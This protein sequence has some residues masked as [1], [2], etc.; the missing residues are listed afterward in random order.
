MRLCFI[1]DARSPI[2]Q[3]W[4]RYFS[5]ER[6][7]L[8]VISS[9]PCSPDVLDV[10]SF[11]TVPVAFSG[12][13]RKGSR[14]K[15]NQANRRQGNI[16]KIL[17]SLLRYM[18]HWPGPFDVLRQ[19]GKVRD[20]ITQIGPDLVHAM[21]VPYEGMLAA[22]AL[23]EIEL[24][25]LI[26][27]WG[28]DFT[29]FAE[30]YPTIA[31]MTQRAIRRADALHP[32]CHRDLRLAKDWGFDDR[33]PAVVL[34]SAGGIQSD[35]F[36]PDSVKPSL[37]ARWAIPGQAPVVINPRGFRGYVRNDTF[38]QAIPLVLK[39]MPSVIFLGAAMEG[40]PIA[41]K[42]IKELH[43][44]RS[45]R[46]LPSVSRDEMA[47]LFRL[48]D[49]TISPSEHDGTPNSLLEAMACGCFPVAG[50][51][52]SVREWIKDGTNGLLCDPASPEALARAILCALEDS[53]LRQRAKQH[54]VTL[55]AERAAYGKVMARAEDFYHHIDV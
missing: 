8:H 42:W 41:E 12:L 32:D 22:E 50:D 3:N 26:S 19:A 16:Q 21:R 53:H 30:R 5:S 47:D 6:Y 48:A 37:Q 35:V 28:N 9:Y 46:L 10:T 33:K 2:A 40:N 20:I 34:P 17:K 45:V 7:E 18:R 24:P 27:V 51:I 4:I 29:L 52:E 44:E 55:I 11:H 49:I 31:W 54:N 36:Y 13:V 14:D 39:K 15:E 38:F 25:L 43:I 1:V 23:K